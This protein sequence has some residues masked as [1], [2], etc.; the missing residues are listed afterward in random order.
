MLARLPIGDVAGSVDHVSRVCVRG[1]H[2]PRQRNDGGDADPGMPGDPRVAD[3]G[4]HRRNRAGGV[5][6]YCVEP[7]STAMRVAVT[8]RDSSLASH[9]TVSAISSGSAT[10]SGRNGVSMFVSCGLVSAARVS[11]ATMSPEP[12][13]VL[14][15]PGC[16]L[17]TRIEYLPSSA[18]NARAIPVTACLLAV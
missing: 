11:A 17:L 6:Q 13:S 8:F 10:Q 7:W 18:A 9:S 3:V 1:D 15:G 14:T 2:R 5:A 16:T 4:A 12:M